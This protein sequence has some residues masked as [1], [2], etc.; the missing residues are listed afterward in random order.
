ML[1]EVPAVRTKLTRKELTIGFIKGW[2]RF[3]NTY[4]KRE[5]IAVIFAQMAGETGLAQ[6]LW[7][8]NIGN[9][10]AVDPGKNETR[11]Y[12]ALSGVWEIIN[13]KKI[14]LPKTHPG[15]RF[16]AY[17]SL[18]D[19]VID[20]LK[21]MKT[22]F[23]G[24]WQFIENGDPEGFA[25]K[26]K[27]LHYYTAP[28]ETY[29]KSMKFFFNDFIKRTDFDECLAEALGS[30]ISVLS[31]REVIELDDP[32]PV[33]YIPLD[34]PMEP[35]LITQPDIILDT[36]KEALKEPPKETSI[37]VKKPSL[38][39]FIMNLMKLIIALFGK[40]K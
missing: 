19:G 29:V 16:I 31:Q 34:I 14:I 39:D 2:K 7:N 25:K 10:K 27:A 8:Y 40:R 20:Y 13:G 36:E 33:T 9:Y 37:E 21:H 32:T 38:M 5:Q 1:I 22:R 6:N 23:S 26:L 35:E 30:E 11:K 24:A 18:E 17:D 4:P 3:F 12:I 28:V 15:S